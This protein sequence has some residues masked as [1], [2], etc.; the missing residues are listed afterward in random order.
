MAQQRRHRLRQQDR[1][2]RVDRERLRERIAAQRR[3]ALFRL[4]P[5]PVQQARAV[6]HQLRAGLRLAQALRQPGQ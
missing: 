2:D 3:Q 4:Q 1:A 5:G 6:D